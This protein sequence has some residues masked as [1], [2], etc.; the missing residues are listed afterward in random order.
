MLGNLRNERVGWE[1][2]QQPSQARKPS[3]DGK[4]L[5]LGNPPGHD[6]SMEKGEDWGGKERCV[7][8][9][10]EGTRRVVVLGKLFY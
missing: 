5:C 3:K 2:T 9:K 7:R 8:L 4:G 1:V 6:S 10:V